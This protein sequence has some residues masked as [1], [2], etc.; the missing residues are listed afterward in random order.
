MDELEPK[1]KLATVG[2][3]LGAFRSESEASDFKLEGLKEELK[4]DA[5]GRSTTGV[6]DARMMS[7]V[8]GEEDSGIDGEGEVSLNPICSYEHTPA[9]KA[10]SEGSV[11]R[12]VVPELE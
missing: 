10:R 6:A 3:R 9:A 1:I 2:K 12:D 5:P 11:D 4:L 7:V 8:D